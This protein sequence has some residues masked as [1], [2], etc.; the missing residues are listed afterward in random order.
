MDERTLAAFQDDLLQSLEHAHRPADV[1]VAL[2]AH[3]DQVLRRWMASWD[4]DLVDLAC[5]LVGIW[6]AR[7]EPPRPPP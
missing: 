2:S 5:E 1:S 4:P 3:S 7:D 6:T